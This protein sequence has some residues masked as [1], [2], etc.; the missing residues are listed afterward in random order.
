MHADGKEHS[1]TLATMYIE[2]IT[3][4]LKYL[5]LATVSSMEIEVIP[6]REI[7]SKHT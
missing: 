5:D 3:N 1:C 6:N 4:E 7:F 2:V